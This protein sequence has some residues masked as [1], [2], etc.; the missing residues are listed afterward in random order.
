MAL[1]TR[2]SSVAPARWTRSRASETCVRVWRRVR[3]DVSAVI[4][5]AL[6]ATLARDDG[7]GP[8]SPDVA[9]ALALRCESGAQREALLRECRRADAGERARR[10]GGVGDAAACAD[11]VRRD[12]AAFLVGVVRSET[13]DAVMREVSEMCDEARSMYGDALRRVD[14]KLG[15]EGATRTLVTEACGRGGVRAVL[16]AIE[17]ATGEAVMVEMSVLS[18]ERGADRQV[19]H[20]DVSYD[21]PHAP[22][23]SLFI[24]LQDVTPEMGPTCFVLGTQ[25]KASHDIFPMTKWGEAQ[26]AALEGRVFCDATLRKGDAVLYDARTFHQGGANEY[27]RR[28]LM[29]LTFMKPPVPVAPTR[30]NSNAEWSIRRDVFD[31]QLTVRTIAELDA[32]EQS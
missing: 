1:S 18:T 9:L 5:P 21:A 10:V 27:G 28:A 12:G 2:L 30:R 11:A 6:D 32:L 19:L 24:A 16:E 23:Y 14:A 13:C 3:D 29:A 25:D 15:F 20:P 31:M 8:S 22:L 4:D 17:D 7:L 26:F